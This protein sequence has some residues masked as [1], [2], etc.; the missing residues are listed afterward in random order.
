PLAYAEMKFCP[1]WRDLRLTVMPGVTG[2]WQV[3]S[4][5]HNRFSDWIKYDIEYVQTQ[6][7]FMDLWI[8]FRTIKV[9]L[10]GV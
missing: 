5:D 9:L 3:Q 1:S 6:S 4:R 8:L 7:L 2:L 10:K